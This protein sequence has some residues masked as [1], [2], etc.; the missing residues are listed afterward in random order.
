MHINSDEEKIEIDITDDH[1]E[2][3]N[4]VERIGKTL[5]RY[6]MIQIAVA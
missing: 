5:M 1:N 6:M 3:N 2:L 4:W